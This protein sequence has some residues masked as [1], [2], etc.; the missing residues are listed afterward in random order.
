M[1]RMRGLPLITCP[2]Q[3]FDLYDTL[4]ELSFDDKEIPFIISNTAIF[5][6]FTS[7]VCIQPEP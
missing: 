7:S 6:S 4:A 5:R 3:Y 1:D 2:R